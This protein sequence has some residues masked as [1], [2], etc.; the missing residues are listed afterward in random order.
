[1]SLLVEQDG[2]SETQ[3]SDR[4]V[5]KQLEKSTSSAQ[6]S[7]HK[8]NED[9]GCAGEAQRRDSTVAGAGSAGASFLTRACLHLQGLGSAFFSFKPGPPSTQS[10]YERSVPGSQ[11]SVPRTATFDGSR[12]GQASSEAP[13]SPPDQGGPGARPQ[14]HRGCVCYAPQAGLPAGAAFS[15]SDSTRSTTEVTT[16]PPGLS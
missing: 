11:G 1:M 12:S 16:V 14:R 8:G 7:E 6:R 15:L 13:S 2:D 5:R 9:Q 3:G 10:C 4:P